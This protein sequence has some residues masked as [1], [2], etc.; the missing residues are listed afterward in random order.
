MAKKKNPTTGW[1]KAEWE[2]MAHDNLNEVEDTLLEE[3]A[4]YVANQARVISSLC[5]ATNRQLK[6][7]VLDGI[8]QYNGSEADATKLA[9]IRIAGSGHWRV[10]AKR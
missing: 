9:R 1:T 5:P 2:Q 4:D 3:L 10:P 8:E 7:A 6:K